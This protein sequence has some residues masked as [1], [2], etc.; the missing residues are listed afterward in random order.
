MFKNRISFLVEFEVSPFGS[1]SREA[2]KEQ[3]ST[4]M[5]NLITEMMDPDDNSI[6]AHFDDSKNLASFELLK[7]VVVE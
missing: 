5:T 1:P 4:I 3:A 7:M 2:I 6:V